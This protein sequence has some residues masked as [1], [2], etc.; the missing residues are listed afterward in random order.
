MECWGSNLW[1]FSKCLATNTTNWAT[2]LSILVFLYFVVVV[3]ETGPVTK[4][5]LKLT[6]IF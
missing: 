1:L 4:A 3:V 5:D 6:A 2:S